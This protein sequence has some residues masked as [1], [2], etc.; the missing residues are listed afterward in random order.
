MKMKEGGH[1]MLISRTRAMIPNIS[2]E[3]IRS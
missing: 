3:Q 2:S 1:V